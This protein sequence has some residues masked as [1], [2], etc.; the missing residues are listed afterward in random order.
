[1]DGPASGYRLTRPLSP[2]PTTD[3][4]HRPRHPHI[5]H[6]AISFDCQPSFRVW[7]KEINFAFPD[8]HS[9]VHFFVLPSFGPNDLVM[10]VR[11]YV[12]AQRARNRWDPS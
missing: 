3:P 6:S 4:I 8:Q 9:A 2:I 7:P 11:P 10:C 5:P 12:C 1:M